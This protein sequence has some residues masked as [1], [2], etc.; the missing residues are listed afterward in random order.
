LNNLKKWLEAY[1][2]PCRVEVLDS[3]YSD[4]LDSI[5]NKD[6]G[7]KTNCYGSKQYNAIGILNQVIGPI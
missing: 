7:T 3:I 2:Q 5:P 6:L 1:F 4:K